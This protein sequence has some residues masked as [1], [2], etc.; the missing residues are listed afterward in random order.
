M[1]STATGEIYIALAM[2]ERGKTMIDTL[3]HEMAH[4]RQY[5]T[6]GEA[7]DLTPAHAES[8]TNIAAEVVKAVADRIFDDLL[9][10]V[11]W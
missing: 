1:Y 4:H 7:A 6:M 11:T 9:G 2:M 3:V 5:R 8:M 10:E